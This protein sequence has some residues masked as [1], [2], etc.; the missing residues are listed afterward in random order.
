M[1]G[2]NGING[3]NGGGRIRLGESEVSYYIRYSK[4]AKR[5]ALKIDVKSGLEVILPERHGAVKPE[6]LIKSRES[7]V[8]AGL[9]RAALLKEQIERRS[10]EEN[11]VVLYLGQEYSMVKIIRKDVSPS[12]KKDDDRF[13]VTVPDDTREK[14][15]AVLEK[16]YR[17]EAQKIFNERARAIGDK[18]KLK[19]NRVFVRSQK[20]RWGSCSRLKNLSFNWR[21]V[22]APAQVIDYLVIHE[23]AHIMEMNHSVNFWR[24]VEGA[25]PDYRA[26]RKWLRENGQMLTL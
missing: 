13:Y 6:Q 19:Y 3:N 7:W 5:P 24:L 23:M 21:L 10:S 11:R 26:P 9:E 16:W 8:L 15:E 17:N 22:M 20:T 18:M 25:C 2:H 4:K 12:V 14:T 1:A